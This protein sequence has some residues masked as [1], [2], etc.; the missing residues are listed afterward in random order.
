M[1]STYITYYVETNMICFLFVAF[2]LYSYIRE[3]RG[4][5]EAGWFVSALVTVQVYCI[6]DICAAVFKNQ[7]FPGARTILWAANTIYIMIPLALVIFWN[8]YV[9]E[10]MRALY[11][12]GKVFRFLDKAMPIV[13]LAVCAVCL[14]TPVTHSIFY[15]DEFNSY[16][17]TIGAYAVPVYAYIFMVYETVKLQIIRHN[18]NTLQ[19]KRDADILSWF[20]VPCIFFSL[21]QVVLYGTT[22]SQVGFTMALMIVFIGRQRN[23]ISRD[24]LTGLNNRREY[25]FAIDRLSRNSGSAMIV[26]VDVNDFKG[27][28]DTYGHTEGDNALKGVAMIL[29]KAC[30]NRKHLGSLALYRYGGDEFI[31]VSTEPNVEEQKAIL[32]NAI[33]E[34]TEKWNADSGKEYTISLSTGVAGGSYVGKELFGLVDAADKAMYTVKAERKKQNAGA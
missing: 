28:N 30:S 19:I 29:R 8:R 5:A 33:R 15:L 21:I 4:L 11:H 12:P 7:T 22:V 24:E 9:T 13:S 34:E 17:R 14:S 6:A 18:S 31:M 10:H 32:L 2:V 27:I 1:Q 23:K 16:H 25:E 3:S 26:M 20:A